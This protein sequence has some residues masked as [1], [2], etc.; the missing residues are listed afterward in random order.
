M[1]AKA[2]TLLGIFISLGYTALWLLPLLVFAL[3]F[4]GA[5][6]LAWGHLARVSQGMAPLLRNSLV[7]AG[8]SVI[9]ALVFALPA[10]WYVGFSQSRLS[11]GLES[12]IFIPFFFPAISL[13]VVF[14]YLWSF[15]VFKPMSYTLG[16]ILIA[17]TF[18]NAPLFVAY[19][20]QGLRAIGKST[21]E[22][23]I[24]EGAR[25][26]QLFWHIYLPLIKHHIL[27]AAYLVFS[28]CFASLLIVLS[29]GG[30]RHATLEVEISHALR[31]SGDFGKALVFGLV[32]WTILLGLPA[33]MSYSTKRAAH[34]VISHS[35]VVPRSQLGRY[36]P[37]WLKGFACLLLL[38][39]GGIVALSLLQG[40][41]NPLSGA[42][43][44]EAW[45]RLVR[46]AVP[47][48]VWRSCL[49]SLVLGCVSAVVST[50]IAYSL[51]RLERWW[52]SHVVMPLIGFSSG[53]LGIILLYMSLRTGM[54]LVYMLIAG[55]VLISVPIAYSFLVPHVRSLPRSVLEAGAIDGLSGISRFWYIELPILRPIW[56][57]VSL[58]IFA[59]S[60]A[61]FSIVYTMQARRVF[62][63]LPVVQY[64]M[65]ARKYIPEAAALSTISLIVVMLIFF[66]AS[67]Y[68]QRRSW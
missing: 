12:L 18:Y 9:C 42:W 63:T 59:I 7:Q 33:L 24:S 67:R 11:R 6:G 43:N 17:N 55:Y 61:E 10:G 2:S 54:P 22:A 30:L 51:A 34:D 47:F 41:H 57:G 66:V 16:A 31:G 32:Q 50:T 25:P 68:A 46:G 28:F 60:L 62:P 13:V 4:M 44:F 64:A 48:P 5:D 58:Q 21:I 45:G 37:G 52:T 14:A 40:M 20:G 19:I 36:M 29:L 27:R 23:A 53:F 49:N 26:L 8:L 65:L 3:S 39:E 15:D 35:D 1:R 56:I 38:F